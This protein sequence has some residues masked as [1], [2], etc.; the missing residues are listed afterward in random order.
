MKDLIRGEKSCS[1]NH[2]WAV[3]VSVDH[4]IGFLT[5][6]SRVSRSVIRVSHF[7]KESELNQ[8]TTDTILRF[9]GC[10]TK[11]RFY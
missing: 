10:N 1:S 2:S 9:P 4:L 11:F 5:P 8:R 7:L 6:A 3:V